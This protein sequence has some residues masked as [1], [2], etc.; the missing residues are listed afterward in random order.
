[1][2]NKLQK[3]CAKETEVTFLCIMFFILFSKIARDTITNYYY[4]ISIC[5]EVCLSILIY[6]LNRVLRYHCFISLKHKKLCSH[7]I[8]WFATV[9]IKLL[10]E[11]LFFALTSFITFYVSL[12]LCI[13]SIFLSYIEPHNLYIHYFF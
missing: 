11:C 3:G 1:M 5:L 8:L 13:K 6:H 4:L 10:N 9:Y 2:F 7:N 12:L